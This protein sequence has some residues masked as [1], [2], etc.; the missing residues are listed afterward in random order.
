MNISFKKLKK[1]QIIIIAVISV[2]L[3]VLVPSAIYCGIH[4]ESP[5]AM[6][7][8]MFTANE[9]QLIGNWQGEKGL[10]AYSFK[11]NGTYESYISSFSYTANYV[12]DSSKLTLVNP[13]TPGTVVYDY[14]VHGDTLTL[15]LIEENGKEPEEKEVYKY[16]RVENIRSQ[17]FVD[18]LKDYA[19]AHED[20]KTDENN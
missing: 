6:L 13:A 18:F 10:T 5:K 8:D 1:N 16:K 20:G 14:S 2:L 17:S 3:I 12:A 15:K 11:E 4:G 7:T 9:E 19:A